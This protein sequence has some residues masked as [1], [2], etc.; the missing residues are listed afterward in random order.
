MSQARRRRSQFGKSATAI[1]DNSV[2]SY[3]NLARI[4]NDERSMSS[5]WWCDEPAR[6][7]RGHAA[8]AAKHVWCEKPMAMTVAECQQIIDACRANGVK[9]R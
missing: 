1:A 9:C 2:Y 7:V 3:D 4:A 8:N 5:T 6:Q